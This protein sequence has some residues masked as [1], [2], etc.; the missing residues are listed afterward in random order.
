MAAARRRLD[1]NPDVPSI[2]ATVAHSR[3]L[4]SDD[5]DQLAQAVDLF[6]TSARPLVQASALEDLALSLLGRDDRLGAT[7]RL[8]DALTLYDHAG[9]SWD[10]GR[11]RNQMRRLGVRRRRSSRASAANAWGGLTPSEVNVVNLSAQGLTNREVAARLFL[12]P[13]TVSMHLRHVYAKLGINSRAELARIA[14]TNEPA[15]G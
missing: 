10:A 8:E 5:H 12:S 4:R 14:L 3:G 1:L 6:A 13:H 11:V 9:A 15:A 7:R 2:A